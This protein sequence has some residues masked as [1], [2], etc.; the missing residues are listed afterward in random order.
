VTDESTAGLLAAKVIIDVSDVAAAIVSIGH[1]VVWTHTHSGEFRVVFPLW[2]V[3][4]S[5]NLKYLY[6][7]TAL[8]GDFMI[9]ITPIFTKEQ[10]G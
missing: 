8:Y 5:H 1:I 7:N 3:V 9:E 2:I 10:I 6:K 4:V